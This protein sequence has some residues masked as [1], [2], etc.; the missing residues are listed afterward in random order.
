MEKQDLL[1]IY[2][3]PTHLWYP[4]AVVKKTNDHVIA[5]DDEG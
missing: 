5:K 1:W 2:P 4:G 3:H